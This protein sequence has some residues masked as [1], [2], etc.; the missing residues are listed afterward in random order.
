MTVNPAGAAAT[1]VS[2]TRSRSAVVRVWY[3]P[4]DPLGTTP[5][6]PCSANQDT[7]SAYAA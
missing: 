3:S 5:S 4:S 6:Q 7:L 2:T 1:A